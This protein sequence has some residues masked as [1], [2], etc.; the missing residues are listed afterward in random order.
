MVGIETKQLGTITKYYP[1]IDEETR[2]V[3]DSVMNEAENFWDFT[4]RLAEKVVS[5]NLSEMLAF[6]AAMWV[7]PLSLFDKVAEKFENVDIIRPYILL[8]QLFRGILED[9]DQVLDA[10]DN[11]LASHSDDWLAVN[12]YICKFLTYRIIETGKREHLAILEKARKLIA[13]RKEL[14]C[15]APEIHLQYVSAL[16][17]FGDFENALEHAEMAHKIASEHDDMVEVAYSCLVKAYVLKNY[18]ATKAIQYA[19]KAQEIFELLGHRLGF[20]HVYRHLGL[21][22]EVLGEVDHAIECHRHSIEIEESEDF[23]VRVTPMNIA[24]LY[25]LKGQGEDA[26]EILGKNF[27]RV[28]KIAQAH[29]ILVRALVLIGHLEK[30]EECLDNGQELMIQSGLDSDKGL[31]YMTRGMLERAKGEIKSALRSYK[32][33]LK[34]TENVSH[35]IHKVPPLIGLIE[36]EMVAFSETNEHQHLKNA[37]LLL[38]RLEQLANEQDLHAVLIQVAILK[39]AIHKAERRIDTA[40][41]ILIKAQKLT[42]SSSMKYLHAKVEEN[43]R[44]LDIDESLSQITQRFSTDIRGITVPSVQAKE[45]SFKVLGCIVMLRE[46]G[47]EVYSKYVDKKLTSDPSMVAGLISAVSS[48]TKELRENG[49]GELQSI[50]HQDIAVLLEHGKY[51]TCALLSDKDT[52]DARVIERRFLEQFEED[53]S[54]DL[55]KFDGKVAGFRAAD[56]LFE[57]I[58]GKK[59]E[60]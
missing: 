13:T 12:M 30:A 2:E 22:S 53:F 25:V 10:I 19:N 16:Y 4:I 60:T 55:V 28:E 54:D 20:S 9:K 41:D 29:F 50:V 8:S 47:L 17:D 58:L 38:S 24:R 6:F 49:H 15:L 14:S 40:R 26:L 5:E 32:R 21:I 46:A 7:E 51:V 57:S 31:Y 37:E 36:M 56:K 18:D 27:D 59:V 34:A 42:Q 48:F 11:V 39:A 3:L 52:Y 43:L 1:F 44:N 33:A 45:I 23:H 35:M